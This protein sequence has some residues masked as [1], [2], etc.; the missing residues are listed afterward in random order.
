MKLVALAG[1]QMI[2]SLGSSDTPDGET[3][4]QKSFQC[5][6]GYFDQCREQCEI[7]SGDSCS[8]IGVMYVNGASVE[9]DEVAAGELYQKAC[10][11]NSA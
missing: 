7:G 3:A 10:N 6:Y 2:M 8:N 4:Q 9:C 5:E 1:L 11:L